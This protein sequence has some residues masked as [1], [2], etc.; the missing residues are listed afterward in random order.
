MAPSGGMLKLTGCEHFRQ[1]IMLSCLSGRAIRIEDIRS[2][3]QAP[4][5]RGFEA[6]LLRLAEKISN[7]C[8]V[9]INETGAQ[10][11]PPSGHDEL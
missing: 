6:S 9:E 4:G 1:R 5:L 7:G 8:V 11:M 10:L 3:D 2:D